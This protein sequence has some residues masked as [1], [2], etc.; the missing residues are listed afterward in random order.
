MFGERK[1]PKISKIL[2]L[3][4]SALLALGTILCG[5]GFFV[6]FWVVTDSITSGIFQICEKGLQNCQSTRNLSSIKFRNAYFFPMLWGLTICGWI[7]F[8]VSILFLFF[9]AC[10]RTINYCKVALGLTMLIFLF[11]ALCFFIPI[12]VIYIVNASD[13]Q[14]DFLEVL[15][16]LNWGYYLTFCGVIILMAGAILFMLHMYFMVYEDVRVQKKVVPYR[17]KYRDYY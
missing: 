7:M 3:V 5:I 13:G 12:V 8:G 14:S 9:Y 15:R 4:G 2:Y 6:P 17:E 1:L 10:K 16:T 11:L